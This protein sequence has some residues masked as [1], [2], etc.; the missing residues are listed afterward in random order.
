MSKVN[1]VI[2]LTKKLNK[3][4]AAQYENLVNSFSRWRTF[5]QGA[6]DVREGLEWYLE[7]VIPND[8]RIEKI[9]NEMSEDE[10]KK[11]YW[12]SYRKDL[13]ELSATKLSTEMLE[14]GYEINLEEPDPDP[15]HLYLL[16]K[17]TVDAGSDYEDVVNECDYTFTHDNILGSEILDYRTEQDGDSPVLYIP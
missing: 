9:L 11:A 12:H 10:M 13:M 3:L 7:Q 4:S 5:N 17:L 15:W 16:V 8:E 2:E 6:R 14:W 1:D